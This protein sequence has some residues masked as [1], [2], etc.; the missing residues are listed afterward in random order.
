MARDPQLQE[1]DCQVVVDRALLARI[2]DLERRLAIEHARAATFAGQV[3]EAK[4]TAY[5]AERC[6]DVMREAACRIKP[7]VRNGNLDGVVEA[8]QHITSMRPKGWRSGV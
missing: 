7:M 2:E 3:S 5:N 4:D 6:M 1:S 8:A